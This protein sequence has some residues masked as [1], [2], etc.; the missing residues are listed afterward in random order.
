MTTPTQQQR[1]PSA[2]GE[3]PATDGGQGSTPWGAAIESLVTVVDGRRLAQVKVPGSDGSPR[4]VWFVRQG[5]LWQP[6]RCVAG[7]P[8][9]HPAP[10]LAWARGGGRVDAKL[11]DGRDPCRHVG[12]AR[13]LLHRYLRGERTWRR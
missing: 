12:P 11:R 5:A 3:G 9:R 1:T 8:F 6:V 4:W 13:A 2:P 7:N 10:C